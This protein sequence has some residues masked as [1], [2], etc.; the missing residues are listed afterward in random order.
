MLSNGVREGAA[1][2]VTVSHQDEPLLP[3]DR[4]FHGDHDPR[5]KKYGRHGDINP[6]NIL[7]YD[8]SDEAEHMLTG[9][10]KIADFGQAEVNSYLSKTKRRDV[11]NTL[12]YRPPECDAQPSIIRQPY[13]IWCLGCV[14]L[15]FVSWLLGGSSLVIAFSR[16]RM[17]PDV[18]QCNRDSDTFFQVDRNPDTLKPEFMIKPAVS[19]VST[20]HN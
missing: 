19:Q 9:T 1:S 15:E 18:F 13:D 10:L 16:K 7:W 4:V 8:D 14:Y 20:S 5:R 17:T 2:P 12:T 6:G 3:N 11:A